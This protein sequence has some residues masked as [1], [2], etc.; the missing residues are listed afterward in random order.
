MRH[1]KDQAVLLSE[2]G[3]WMKRWFELIKKST[4]DFSEVF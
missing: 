3:Q 2:N 4:Y 1:P